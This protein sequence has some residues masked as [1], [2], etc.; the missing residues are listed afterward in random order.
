MRRLTPSGF[1]R[2]STMLTRRICAPHASLSRRHAPVN[3]QPYQAPVNES[4]RL[5]QPPP[6]AD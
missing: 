5:V 2:E 1:C 4:H 3:V 6:R